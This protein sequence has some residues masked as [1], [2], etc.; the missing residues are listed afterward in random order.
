M[1]LPHTGVEWVMAPDGTRGHSWNYITGC[2]N[3]CPYC[4]ARGLAN[5]RL[6]TRYLAN[7][8]LLAG[9][10]SDPFAPR[11]WPERLSWP[12]QRKKPTMI[13]PCDMGEWCGD[14]V[15]E[16]EVLAMLHVVMECPQHT[17]AFLTKQPQCLARYSPFP[18]NMWVGVS[19]TNDQQAEDACYYFEDLFPVD[20][21][22]FASFEP[23]TE[24][25]APSLLRRLS[26][27]VG[28][29]IVGGQTKP[30]VD[31]QPETVSTI[32]D[33]FDPYGIPVFLKDSLEGVVAPWM[34]EE[35]RRIPVRVRGGV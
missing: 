9:N 18:R 1:G 31:P 6:K 35:Y 27:V 30:R 33:H 11:V 20:G 32:I 34:F 16:A 21:L 2:L 14:W 7:P 13:F 28:W 3:G 8:C 29:V 25:I 15:P 19:I 24:P 12:E 17:F 26:R 23:L 22:L 10:Y 4:Y 5:G